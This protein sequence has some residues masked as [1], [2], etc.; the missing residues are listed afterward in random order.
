MGLLK[1]LGFA[2][3]KTADNAGSSLLELLR[4]AIP[5]TMD[6]YQLDEYDQ[7]LTKLS[8]EMA[9]AEQRKD[10]ETSEYDAIVETHNQLI[11][12]V[13]ATQEK[14][15]SPDT[16]PGLA[17]KLDAHLKKLLDQ[18][19]AMRPDIEREKTE[20]ED[21]VEEFNEMK[22]AV[23]E[24]ARRS[25]NARSELSR[26]KIELGKLEREQARIN[27]KEEH[28]KMMAGI[29][30]HVDGM[31]TILSS[32]DKEI[33]EKRNALR[34]AQIRVSARESASTD[35]KPEIDPEVAEALGKKPQSASTVST[36]DRIAALKRL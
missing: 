5:E 30:Q 35:Q 20:A 17:I 33:A 19:D 29:K 8:T 26:R 1:A 31:G 3:S 34:A 6:E 28:Q 12:D 14:I 16:S 10:K 24:A 2:A 21:A 11:G 15:D 7:I 9:A 18:I 27:Q 25:A 23:E 13:Q 36:A 4:K 32:Y 22:E